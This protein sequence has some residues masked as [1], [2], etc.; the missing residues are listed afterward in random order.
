MEQ[1][2]KHHTSMGPAYLLESSSHI[3]PYDNVAG[4]PCYY[5]PGDK[6]CSWQLHDTPAFE[7]TIPAVIAGGTGEPTGALPRIGVVL[8]LSLGV[9][10]YGD[11]V[12]V[13]GVS[14]ATLGPVE[15][16]LKPQ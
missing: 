4:S 2:E 5:Y 9:P 16:Q 10:L 1:A 15:A 14:V 6:E 3:I 7:Q 11:D 8:G 13:C 12:L